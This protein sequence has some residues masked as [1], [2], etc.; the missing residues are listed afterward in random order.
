MKFWNWI[1]A[2]RAGPSRFGEWADLTPSRGSMWIMLALVLG[3]GCTSLPASAGY[4]MAP[5]PGSVVQLQATDRTFSPRQVGWNPRR[6]MRRALKAVP[7]HQLRTVLPHR[8]GAVPQ[9]MEGL[10]IAQGRPPRHVIAQARRTAGLPPSARA[11]RGRLVS[12]NGSNFWKIIFLVG[13]RQV[14]V[15]VPARR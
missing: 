1:S 2:W 14:P 3:A 7:S 10:R 12:R 9:A 13:N 11:L 8:L 15:T 5:K 4:L 6:A